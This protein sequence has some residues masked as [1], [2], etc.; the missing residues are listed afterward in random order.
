MAE[1]TLI[2]VIRD[3]AAQYSW[4]IAVRANEVVHAGAR[5]DEYPDWQW[6]RSDAGREGWVPVSLLVPIEAGRARI[7]E[8]YDATE[9]SV[10][11]G[12]DVRVTR[13]LSQWARV[14]NASGASGWIPESVLASS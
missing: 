5:D 4:P 13:R 8:D 9:L 10:V 11:N 12:E 2:R 3:Y 7:S 1:Q 6:C 14:T